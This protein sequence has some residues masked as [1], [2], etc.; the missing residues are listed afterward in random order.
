MERIKNPHDVFDK[1]RAQI[2]SELLSVTGPLSVREDN[3]SIMLYNL[4]QNDIGFQKDQ[5][6]FY[7]EVFREKIKDYAN[8]PEA[9]KLVHSKYRWG[10][11]SN[12]CGGITL[13][14]I[15]FDLLQEYFMN[16]FLD[17]A[18]DIKLLSTR[19]IQKSHWRLKEDTG[20]AKSLLAVGITENS[21]LLVKCIFGYVSQKDIEYLF[22][23]QA[24]PNG[25]APCFIFNCYGNFMYP[26]SD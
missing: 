5:D 15:A 12:I 4:M 26:P 1:L 18:F 14:D 16:F 19:E 20:T 9:Y 6:L 23:R 8:Y 2:A 24:Y 21:A 13:G 17:N 7:P 10:I 22:T 3:A 25:V 11:G